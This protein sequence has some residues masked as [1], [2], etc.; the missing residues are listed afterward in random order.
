MWLYIVGVLLVMFGIVGLFAG[1]IYGIVLIP[2]GLIALAAAVM[3]GLWARRAQGAA[4]A[5]TEAHPTTNQPLP[6][7]EHGDPGH[8]P[9]SPE[10]L[11]DARRM[12]Q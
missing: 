7:H 2:L 1:G 11:A 8:V 9:T 10:A 4:G 12:Q 5:R 6:H 3:S